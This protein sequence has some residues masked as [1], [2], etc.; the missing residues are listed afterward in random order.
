M[1]FFT[2]DFIAF[3][4]ELAENNHKT[5]FDANRK[6]YEN[7]VKKPFQ[8]FIAHL[9][10]RV[11]ED[12]PSVQITPKDAIFRINRD[13]RF[14]KDKTPYKTNVSA[15]ISPGGRKDKSYPG[16]YVELKTDEIRYYGG[17]H[18]L[19]KQQL[20]N[21]RNHI[22]SHSEDFEALLNAQDFKEKFGEIRGDQQKR[23]P[24][25]LK[26]AAEK[27][28]LIFNKN[29]YYFAKLDAKYIMQDDLADV[30]MEYYF[31]AKPMMMFLREG[32]GL[33]VKV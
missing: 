19:E 11:Q 1:S 4:E 13:I 7:S 8:N 2:P 16:I 28:P 15:I 6:R 33:E 21:V 26:E 12:D 29:F 23:I 25:D 3:F 20:S 22:A 14:S 32:M 31:A 24:K 30:L 10:D 17:A 5:W 18:M 27:Q 9:I